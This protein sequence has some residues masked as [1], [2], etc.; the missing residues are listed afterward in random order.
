M[1]TVYLRQVALEC[2][3]RVAGVSQ[4]VDRIEVV[5]VSDDC[6]MQECSAE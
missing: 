4:V 5:Y 2:I 1:P 3:Q 6:A